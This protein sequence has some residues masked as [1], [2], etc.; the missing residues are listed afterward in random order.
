[1]PSD[2][3]HGGARPKIDPDDKRGG[4]RKGAGR[5]PRRVTIE[6]GR[7]LTEKLAVL[8]AAAERTAETQ[9]AVMLIPLIHEAYARY[10]WERG[11]GKGQ[12]P[13]E[14]GGDVF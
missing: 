1:M 7:E 4:K 11:I 2:R 8:A 10:E 9:A 6:L 13:V 14:W 3:N 5:K 12:D